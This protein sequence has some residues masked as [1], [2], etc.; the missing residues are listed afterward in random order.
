MTDNFRRQFSE[1]GYEFQLKSDTHHILAMADK[2][3]FRQVYYNLID[4]AI[5]YSGNSR[6]IEISLAL[7]GDLCISI[8]DFGIGIERKDLDKIF[9]RFYRSEESQKLGI[10]GSGIGLTLV[11]RIVEAHEGRVKVES[12]PGKGTVIYI[13]LPVYKEGINEKDTSD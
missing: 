13:Y 7:Q 12:Q 5:K 2:E 10:K 8:R 9:D 3:A 6:K 11:K 1:N 4:N